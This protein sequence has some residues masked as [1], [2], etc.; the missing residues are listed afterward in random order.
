[1]PD[2]QES[3]P[4][5]ITGRLVT[6]VDRIAADDLLLNLADTPQAQRWSSLP[7]VFTKARELGVNC[8]LAGFYHA[9]PR[10]FGDKLVESSS[11]SSL[12]LFE[13]PEYW[14]GAHGLE[15]LY[16]M[17]QSALLRVPLLKRSGLLGNWRERETS[18]LIYLQVRDRALKL[19]RRPEIGLVFLHFPIPHPLGFYDR[20]TD[21]LTTE[22]GN[23]DDNLA[24][25]D[26]TLG[27]LRAAM[28]RSGQW[29]NSFV[30]LTT[31]HPLREEPRHEG[32]PFMLKAPEQ[33]DGLLYHEPFNSIL[34]QDLILA[35]LRGEFRADREASRWLDSHRLNYIPGHPVQAAHNRQ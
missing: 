22:R 13:E 23:Y 34:T 3:V 14:T 29:E 19:L 26:R 11:I 35:A 8:A 9:Y 6:R 2:T 16:R 33:K 25:V 21:R 12:A 20:R 24:L 30:L 5:L 10:V 18:R 15:K 28:E 27:E 1:M 31:D 4:S 17:A 32:I 7:N